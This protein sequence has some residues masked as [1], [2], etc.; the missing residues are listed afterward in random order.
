MTETHQHRSIGCR[1]Q[2]III[3]II[4][5]IRRRRIIIII[6]TIVIRSKFLYSR[7]VWNLLANII[8]QNPI[9]FQWFSGIEPVQDHMRP[10]M[11]ERN[12]TRDD[13]NNDDDDDRN[14]LTANAPLCSNRTLL[15][16]CR[17]DVLAVRET[18]EPVT[19]GEQNS[20]TDVGRTA[21]ALSGLARYSRIQA[22]FA[23]SHW[24]L[25]VSRVRQHS[26]FL[27][28]LLGI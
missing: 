8:S 17:R 19:F 18:D 20:P 10:L 21:S 12:W 25:K 11:N 16:R 2:A 9:S 23:L 22:Q 7:G 15:S 4:I 3:I 13:N 1:N 26:Q 5:I 14:V 28:L 6:T 24:R 27:E